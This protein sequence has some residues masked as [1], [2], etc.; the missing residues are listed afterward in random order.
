LNR[1]EEMFAARQVIRRAIVAPRFG[2]VGVASRGFGVSPKG[3]GP[4]SPAFH[5]SP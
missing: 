1:G 2:Q 5:V 3:F 4:G